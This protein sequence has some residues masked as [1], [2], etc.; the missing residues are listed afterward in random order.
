M[1]RRSWLGAPLLLAPILSL[2]SCEAQSPASAA[3]PGDDLG[4][5]AP[6]SAA[7]GGSDR[8]VSWL[9]WNDGLA[10]ARRTH[11]PILLFVYADWCPHC[12]ELAP[13]W[14]RPEVKRLARRLV[15]IRQNSDE[16][17]PWLEERFGRFGGYVP[18]VF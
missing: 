2:L 12:R 11:R 14:E 3:A 16:R 4:P 13:V 10:V 9:T 1:T 8:A 15:M 5:A 7:E 18:R 17:P 6:P